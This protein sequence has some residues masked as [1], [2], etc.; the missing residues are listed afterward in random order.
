MDSNVKV[1]II[2]GI[3]G[4]LTGLVTSYLKPTKKEEVETKLI[5]HPLFTRV[6]IL[7]GDVMRN[8]SLP[9]KGKERIFKDIIDNQLLIIKTHLVEIAKK[10]DDDCIKD[11]THLYNENM[12]CYNDILSQL[13]T[14]Y[15]NSDQYTSEEKQ[16]LDI[17]MKK[18]EA[19]NKEYIEHIPDS[20]DMAC[21]SPFYNDIQ[22][23]TAAI[24]DNYTSF[25]VDT[26]NHAGK[27]LNSLNGDLKGLKFKNIII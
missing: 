17:V 2:T 25:A 22:T 21:N 11:T 16:V 10:V 12:K 9:N 7:R 3:F 5:Y 14:Y 27:T 8:F 26:I 15:H 13:H 4:L 1:A 18:Y 6:D 24:F 23:K 19:W 20:I